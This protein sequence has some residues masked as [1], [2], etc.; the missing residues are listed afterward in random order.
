M[1]GAIP[2]GVDASATVVI[3]TQEDGPLAASSLKR[4]TRASLLISF[5]T[6]FAKQSNEV[7]S[8][9]DRCGIP[10]QAL[11]EPDLPL[12]SDALYAAIEMMADTLGNP[13]FGAEVAAA[14][15]AAG[16]DLLKNSGQSATLGEFL[17]R[18]TNEV[19][20]QVTNVK[21]S[22]EV[23][24]YSARYL[25]QRQFHPASS[26][27]QA[28]AAGCVFYTEIIKLFAGSMFDKND[29]Q[30]TAPSIDGVPPNFLPPHQL[31]ANKMNRF[32]WSFP[33][34]WLNRRGSLKWTEST[35]KA[36]DK[37]NEIRSSSLSIIRDLIEANLNEPDFDLYAL[38]ALTG[39]RARTIQ[40]ALAHRGMSFVKLRDDVRKKRAT[41]LLVETEMSLREIAHETGYS[42]PET[43]S[44][45][46]RKW[47]GMLPSE[48][49]KQ[50][51]ISKK[52]IAAN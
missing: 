51:E 37:T 3:S 44:R 32:I 42:T 52:R 22:L 39:V 17:I 24:G 50:L 15:A 33:T 21:H 38:A 6:P 14:A 41:Q 16:V 11:A 2:I 36:S 10:H 20:S 45:A 48:Y 25:I 1:V 43:F 46:F 27:F 28:D 4:F 29:I 26:T 30:V 8:I 35:L 23:R 13:Y 18:G 5:A 31:V 47:K 40:R 9:L 7:E 34:E 12:E 49:R 19:E